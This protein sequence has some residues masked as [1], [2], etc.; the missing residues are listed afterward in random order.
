MRPTVGAVET[1]SYIASVDGDPSPD[2]LAGTREGEIYCFAGGSGL[3]DVREPS[4][5]D[6]AASHDL[7]NHPNPFGPATTI[8][9]RVPRAMRVTLAIFDVQGRMVRTLVADRLAP[10]MH[11]AVWTGRDQAGRPVAAGIYFARLMVGDG[12]VSEKITLLR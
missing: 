11:M 10:G 12:I 4:A 5:E 8:H 6:E 2:I 3:S 9:Y 7:W 1:V